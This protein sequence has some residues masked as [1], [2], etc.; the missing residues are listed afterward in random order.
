MHAEVYH[1]RKLH[2]MLSG[3]NH[4]LYLQEIWSIR[5]HYPIPAEPQERAGD[6]SH[7]SRNFK[8]C[9]LSICE[10]RYDH[11]EWLFSQAVAIV[12]V[13]SHVPDLPQFIDGDEHESNGGGIDA[14]QSTDDQWLVFHQLPNTEQSQTEC[15]PGHKDT[16]VA[17]DSA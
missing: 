1:P 6:D 16:K 9:T 4:I 8:P 5:V 2:S 10:H 7:W 11:Q 13:R 15:K 17:E 14:S 12:P 3:N